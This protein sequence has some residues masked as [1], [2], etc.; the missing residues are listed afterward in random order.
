M[1]MTSAPGL[2]HVRNEQFIYFYQIPNLKQFNYIWA[3]HRLKRWVNILTVLNSDYINFFVLGYSTLAGLI[4]VFMPNQPTTGKVK[5]IWSIT[6]QPSTYICDEIVNT[7]RFI[8]L[9]IVNRL[10][11]CFKYRFFLCEASFT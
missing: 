5:L 10:K 6:Y 4:Y 3:F 8:F 7:K 1:Y 2:W 11:F 9:W